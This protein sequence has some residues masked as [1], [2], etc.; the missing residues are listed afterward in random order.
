MNNNNIFDNIEQK[1]NVTKDQ[2]F[3]IAD[4][5]KDANFKDE[6]TV[7]QLVRQ[8]AMMAGKNISKEKE[9]QIVRAVIENNMPLDLASLANMFSFKK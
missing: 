8:V 2:I 9:D 3:K 7:R 1:S 4:S 5:V 6:K